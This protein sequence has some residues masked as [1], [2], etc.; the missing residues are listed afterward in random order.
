MESQYHYYAFISYNH[1]D[2]KVAKWLQR[3]LEHYRLP[4][5]ARKEIGRDVKI[6]PVFRYAVNLS[7]GD[8]REKI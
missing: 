4:A 8:L 5:I 2:E 3:Q 1:R 7:L 6:R